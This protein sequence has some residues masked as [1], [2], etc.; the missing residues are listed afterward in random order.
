MAKKTQ[1]KVEA[2]KIDKVWY[3]VEDF[4]NPKNASVYP[5]ESIDG[6]VKDWL[7]ENPV[8]ATEDDIYLFE[9]RLL[10]KL[11]IETKTTYEIK[12]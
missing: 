9:V 12:Q 3:A 2:E 11:S 5:Y 1:K 8:S 10:G 4:D 6:A 7:N